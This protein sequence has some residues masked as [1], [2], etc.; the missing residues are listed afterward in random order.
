MPRKFAQDA[1]G[2]KQ[3]R[4]AFEKEYARALAND[5]RPRDVNERFLENLDWNLAIVRREERE[6]VRSKR[7]HTNGAPAAKGRRSNARASS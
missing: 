4:L 1:V 5:T 3:A 7:P 6:L 2:L